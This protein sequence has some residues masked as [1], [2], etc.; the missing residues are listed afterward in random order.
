MSGPQRWLRAK[1][2]F[3][4]A[5]DAPPGVRAQ[6]VRQRAGDDSGLAREVAE[7]LELHGEPDLAIDT[8]SPRERF[9]EGGVLAGRYRIER[10]LGGGGMGEVF[11]AIDLAGGERVAIKAI[12]PLL[13][14]AARAEERFLREVRMA[15]KIEHRNVCRVFD[16]LEHG[17]QRFCVMELL[18]GETLAK[19]LEAGP[20]TPDEALPVVRDLCAG[21]AAAHA[22]GVVH[23]DLKPSNILLENGRAV[24]IDFGLAAATALEAG[25]TASGEVIGTLAYMAPEQLS[26]GKASAASDIYSLGVVMFEMLMGRKPHVA[27][28]PLRLVAEKARDTSQSERLAKSGIP[29]VWQEAIERCLQ[30][31]PPNRFASAQD[32]V[33][34]LARG[35]ASARFL[36]GRRAV[37]G[38][39]S[40]VLGF[41]LGFG[42]WEL[43]RYDYRTP[44]SGALTA[45]EQAREALANAAPLRATRLLEAAAAADDR[46]VSARAALAA[47]YMEL[48]QPERARDAALE[49]AAAA[50]RRWVLG[51]GER[52]E[53]RAARA[54]VVRN[55]TEAAVQYRALADRSSG[56]ARTFALI[57]AGRA[58]DGNG[59]RAGALRA[60]EH[61]VAQDPSSAAARIRLAI[62]LARVGKPEQAR[63]EF[64]AAERLLAGGD[65]DEALSDLL[66][67]RASARVEG[68][69][70]DR[71]GLER[72]LDLSGKT[73]NRYHA[74]MAKLR[75]ATLA[76]VARDYERGES[77]A[78]ETA[79]TARREGMPALAAQA[80]SE[81]GYANL[82]RKRPDLAEPPLREA[83]E[84]ADRA[85]AS[86]VA[87][88]ARLRLGEVLGGLHRVDEAV[89]VMEPAVAWMR[90]S[91]SQAGLPLILIKWVTI[92]ANTPRHGEVGALL[93]E[94][95]SLAARD[96]NRLY[97]AMAVQ[98]MAMYLGERN[99]ARGAELFEEAN[100]LNPD[101]HGPVFQGARHWIVAARYD[102][103][104]RLLAKAE[105]LTQSYREGVDKSSHRTQ[106]LDARARIAA[107][108][109]Q[110]QLVE[111][112]QQNAAKELAGYEVGLHASRTCS[113]DPRAIRE[114]LSWLAKRIAESGPGSDGHR[115]ILRAPMAAM[116]LNLGDW[117]NARDT[118]AKGIEESKV[119]GL[120][121][122]ELENLLPLRAALHALGDTEKARQLEPRILEI[123]R[124][125]FGF[126][127]PEKFGGRQDLLR[128]W[129]RGRVSP[130]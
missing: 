117:K 109:G 9:R 13:G 18:R 28:S 130:R 116:Y 86:G 126:D 113:Q 25:L 72:V 49:A 84:I 74:L 43:L 42:G 73:G 35:R 55:F 82:Y 123:S 54:A 3:S 124:E 19:R 39:A 48:D 76:L 47:A 1:E 21:L 79:E 65:H 125:N 100:R 85:R 68:N 91:G 98:R 61:A 110:C 53:L 95:R 4:E 78:R 96:G 11:E 12:R 80:L 92:L 77:L 46:F 67:A 93:R 129:E 40:A 30:T 87:A 2:I 127:P 57:A 111:A 106:V 52:F 107:G 51:D 5:L 64:G 56:S 105:A 121:V 34:T 60:L 37:W 36:L 24:I 99:P 94:A 71:A 26:E 10:R 69:E 89:G 122:W 120:T 44:A 75:L 58:L 50:D 83:V 118:A 62:L 15:R 102:R 7:L 20:M 90:E 88:N 8:L 14:E 66:L 29:R 103:A 104:E 63:A 108:R 112:L 101:L 41:A 59:D 23:R 32:V 16:L 97:E 115:S 38:P 22:A 27:R 128:L 119:L 6:L 81:L 45:Y 17:G 114:S 31:W 70:R 33:R